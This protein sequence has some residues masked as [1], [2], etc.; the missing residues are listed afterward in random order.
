[1]AYVFDPFSQYGIVAI[2]D[3][4]KEVSDLFLSEKVTF[5]LLSNAKIFF[6]GYI[7]SESSDVDIYAEWDGV[8]LD[9]VSCHHII[10]WP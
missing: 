9:S 8:A 6:N 7:I 1:M 10:W 5:V 3:V 2:S 4:K